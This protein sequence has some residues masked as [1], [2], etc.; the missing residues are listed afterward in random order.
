[1]GNTVLFQAPGVWPFWMILQRRAFGSSTPCASVG[2]NLIVRPEDFDNAP[3]L[4]SCECGVVCFLGIDLELDRKKQRDPSSVEV[5]YVGSIAFCGLSA[6]LAGTT[7]SITT[8]IT[9][10]PPLF[11]LRSV[12]AEL[13]AE[14]LDLVLQETRRSPAANFAAL[15]LRLATLVP[16]DIR[17]E[18]LPRREEVTSKCAITVRAINLLFLTSQV[19]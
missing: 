1:V 2:R 3:L 7:A 8:S 19:G 6:C 15:R 18:K 11:F 12:H 4:W 10:R 5:S 16:S 17:E 14:K 9:L 13:F